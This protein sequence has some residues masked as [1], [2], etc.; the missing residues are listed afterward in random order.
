MSNRR[1]RQKAEVSATE[2][3]EMAFCEKRVLLA[4]QHGDRSTPEQRK[5]KARGLAA[6]ERYLV[7]GRATASDRR[8]FVASCVY[9][10]AAPETRLLR[11]YRDE[12]LLPRRWGRCLVAVYY[13]VGPLAC[14]VLERSPAAT[15]MTRKVLNVLTALCRR[16]LDA[17]GGP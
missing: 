9:G 17:R 15:E 14:H 4:H 2:L 16:A 7:E 5:A 3:A 11:I 6:H 1:V 13:R 10:P 12:V 8:C